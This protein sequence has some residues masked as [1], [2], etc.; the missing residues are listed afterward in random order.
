MEHKKVTIVVEEGKEFKRLSDDLAGF[1]EVRIV[2]AADVKQSLSKLLVQDNY[3]LA[4]LTITGLILVKPDE[5]LLFEYDERYWHVL[6]TDRVRYKL[7]INTTAKDILNFHYSLAQINQNCVVNLNYLQF[8]ENT[9]NKCVF[10]SA[11]SD[12]TQSVSQRY[13]KKLKDQPTLEWKL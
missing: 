11:F 13:Y 7:K 6:L 8:I 3:R 2:N 4:I 9:T 12:I 5:I 1:T 10:R